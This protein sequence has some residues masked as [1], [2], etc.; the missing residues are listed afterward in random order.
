MSRLDEDGEDLG[1]G[2]R[3][4][5]AAPHDIAADAAGAWVTNGEDGTVTRLDADG[6]AQGEPIRVGRDPAGILL[7]DGVVWVTNRTR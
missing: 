5:A 1:V 3:R 6:R 7:A 4:S 2:R